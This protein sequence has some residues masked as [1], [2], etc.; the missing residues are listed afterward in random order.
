MKKITIPDVK[1]AYK[2]LKSYI[3]YD[4]TL[5]H[6]R[7]ALA[8]FEAT[9]NLTKKLKEIKKIVNTFAEDDVTLLE[10][11]LQKIDFFALPKNISNP[12]E[13]DSTNI[14]INQKVQETYKVDKYNLF[15][16]CPI[17]LH[18]ISILWIMKIGFKFDSLLGKNIYGY[19]LEKNHEGTFEEASYKLYEKYHEKY[20]GFRDGA[21]KKAI[22]LH[23]IGLDVT[24]VNLDIQQFFYNINF[25]FS[26]NSPS[27]EFNR[28]NILM[29]LIHVKYQK[30]I[31]KSK[32]YT[33]RQATKIIPIGLLSSSIVAN[34]SLVEFDTLITD[35]VNPEFYSRYVDDILLVFSNK[36]INLNKSINVLLKRL[37]NCLDKKKLLVFKK[38]LIEIGLKENIFTMQNE[39]TKLFFFAASD[40]IYLL[41]KFS[42]TI[43]NN[44]SLQNLLPEDEE[45]FQTI[46]ES[47]YGITYSS[48]VNKVSSISD[49]AINLLKIS[50]NLSQMINII[51]LTKHSTEQIQVYNKELLKVFSGKNLFD[52][53]RL[54]EKLFVYLVLTRS[55][56]EIIA[57]SIEILQA[58]DKISHNNKYAQSFIKNGLFRYFANSLLMSVSIDLD[59]Y[60][61]QVLNT[62]EEKTTKNLFKKIL[63][64]MS[65]D[66]IRLFAKYII[67]SNLIR[68]QYLQL[69]LVNYCKE[70]EV[71]T[72]SKEPL[73]LKYNN[74]KK[75][76]KKR[77]LSPRFVHFHEVATFYFTK[78]LHDKKKKSSSNYYKDQ[79]DYLFQQ[80][81]DFNKSPLDRNKYPKETKYSMFIEVVIP[82]KTIVKKLKVGIVNLQVDANNSIQ[83]FLGKPNQSFKRLLDIYEILNLSVKTKCDLIIFPEISVPMKWLNVITNFARVHEIGFIFGL[84]H[85]S[86]TKKVYNY[87]VIALPFTDGKYKNIMLDFNL[88][89]NYAP[90]EVKEI[91]GR[92][93][94]IVSRKTTIKPKIYDWKGVLFS[95]FNCYELTDIKKRAG[96]V[97]K[98]DFT[99]A[100]EYNRDTNYF[101]HIV[102]SIARD[103]HS[104]IVQVNN[105]QHGDSRITK[106][107]KQESMDIIKIKG[108]NNVS[109]ITGDIDIKALREFQMKNHNLQEIDKRFKF[110]PPDFKHKMHKKRK[111]F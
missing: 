10:P 45:L 84:E 97:G 43:T 87:S 106:P 101:S 37:F 96:L 18:I 55:K 77:K 26:I 2:K 58:I 73:S 7:I 27:K 52:L 24:L 107:A 80:Y 111:R 94:N 30:S 14:F 109:L 81:Q 88:K 50:Q 95:V 9:E 3:Y 49:S 83:S 29:N 63:K 36:R 38:K 75:D 22:E 110:T 79:F 78:F 35:K 60:E 89:Q 61:I 66:Y 71:K 47:S 1:N 56:K 105:S 100:I 99:V 98:N 4:N 54:W 65:K 39:K 72:L 69:P 11:Y 40:S 33:K 28:L 93:Y 44:S 23:E 76:T 59:F 13:V 53:I 68:H 32:L 16:L 91:K 90:G 67:D 57:L 64:H 6:V 8:E 70:I 12:N 19:R 51:I 46:E 103:I 74:L 34:I 104:Y 42:Q 21:I 92:R 85:F 41:K 15:I 108:G 20:M 17:E 25:D 5:V 102:G 82:S 31:V 48:T 62:L 86:I